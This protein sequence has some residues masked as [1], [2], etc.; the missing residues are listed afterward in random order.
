MTSEPAP[1][2]AG[3]GRLA[4]CLRAVG[5]FL[6]KQLPELVADAQNTLLV[7]A[8]DAGIQEEEDRLLSVMEEVEALCPQAA[9]SFREAVLGK[10]RSPGE[11]IPAIDDA[12][13][14]LDLVETA[15]VDDWVRLNRL[16]VSHPK[17]AQEVENAVWARF[18][19]AL[20]ASAHP[21]DC[22]VSLAGVCV[23]F[24]AAMQELAASR[25]AR[26]AIYSAFESTVV[27]KLN[28]LIAT[29]ERLLDDVSLDATEVVVPEAGEIHSTNSATS[30]HRAA[31]AYDTIAPARLLGAVA[32]MQRQI[33]E[34]PEVQFQDLKRFEAQLARSITPAGV[35]LQGEEK[36]TVEVVARVVHAVLQ[37]PDI[38]EGVKRRLW[39]LTPPLVMLALQDDDYLQTELGAARHDPVTGLLD[40]EALRARLDAAI[41]THARD[42]SGLAVCLIDVDGFGD[43]NARL[44]HQVAGRLLRALG[45]LLRKHAGSSAVVARLRGDEFAVLLPGARP[46]AGR[47][48][49]ER[50]LAALEDVRF[51]FDGEAVRLAVSI[52]AVEADAEL[53][54]STGV[55]QAADVARNAA[56]AVGGGCLRVYG[57]VP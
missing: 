6:D 2:V 51:G 45:E 33:N 9:D 22:P 25:E 4:A 31:D 50:Y 14:G 29:L 54:T 13:S 11:L 42:V 53:T 12:G 36:Q 10:L 24:Q 48:F 55:M 35:E 8:R 27:G 5:S 30:D 39:R 3:A 37:Q 49:A 47:R 16:L 46:G 44:G 34:P 52:G 18:S 32:T 1:P 38:E 41:Q 17:K 43:I 40:R 19:G 21:D 23:L 7:A 20:G 15:K 56:K 57:A 26:S 28:H